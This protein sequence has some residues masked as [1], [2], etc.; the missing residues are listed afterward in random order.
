MSELTIVIGDKNL[1]SNSLRGWLAVEATG[2]GFNEVLIRLD[3]PSTR[4]QILKHSPAAKVPVLKHGEVT[5]WESLAICEYLAERFP[6][7]GLWPDGAEARAHARAI[8]AEM[9]AGFA[10][11]R[12]DMS[13]EF[14]ARK[15]G[16]GRTPEAL[17]EVARVAQIWR[18]CRARFG[19]GGELLFGRFTVADA[20][21]APVV[22]RF[23]TYEP[24]LDEVAA[25]Y[26]HAVW[27]LPAMRA[28]GA[29]A[30]T[31]R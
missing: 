26:V 23:V 6:E 18:H 5:V 4:Q 30:E 13:M 21:F 20:M 1:S 27:A 2:A 8:S 24:A 22:S 9:H 3:R 29:A 15:P 14:R 7:A 11:L 10:A 12:R 25:A 28:W 17:A 16:Q 19:A 31:E